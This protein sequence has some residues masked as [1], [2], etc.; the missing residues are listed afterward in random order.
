MPIITLLHIV[1]LLVK[2][3]QLIFGVG[4]LFLNLHQLV[5]SL[6][7]P[8]RRH[9]KQVTRA[10]YFLLI[11]LRLQEERLNLLLGVHTVD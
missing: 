4:D 1:Q 9:M 3:H 8:F 2:V 10:P 6:V 11:H 5:S 7:H